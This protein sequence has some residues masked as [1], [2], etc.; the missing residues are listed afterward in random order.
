MSYNFG[1][2]EAIAT[3]LGIN[4]QPEIFQIITTMREDDI[5]AKI[6]E[7]EKH[8][9]ALRL[10]RYEIEAEIEG[11]DKLFDAIRNSIG[12]V[13]RPVFSTLG[14][15]Y[16]AEMRRRNAVKFLLDLEDGYRERR[17]QMEEAMHTLDIVSMASE[18]FTELLE[19]IGKPKST[20]VKMKKGT[21]LG[22]PSF[23]RSSFDHSCAMPD[24]EKRTFEY[25][26]I[27]MGLRAGIS[28][29]EKE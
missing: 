29:D 6:V 11:C 27:M 7:F 22:G 16:E 8:E 13:Q 26:Q 2:I 28:A 5:C 20:G 24:A 17:M 23:D 12:D 21:S 14:L 1:K 9:D 18:H 19:H 15:T 10:K 3:K 4:N 25:Q